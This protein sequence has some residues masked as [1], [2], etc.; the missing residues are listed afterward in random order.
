MH[1]FAITPSLFPVQAHAPKIR[2]ISQKTAMK[3]RKRGNALLMGDDCE[4]GNERIKYIVTRDL[5][6]TR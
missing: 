2:L 1:S 4:C 6:N 5:V 3:E